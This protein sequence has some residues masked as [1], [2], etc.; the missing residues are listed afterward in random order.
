MKTPLWGACSVTELRQLASFCRLPHPCR[1]CLRGVLTSQHGQKANGHSRTRFDAAR[2]WP[3]SWVYGHAEKLCS[4]VSAALACSLPRTR[5]TRGRQFLV[6]LGC[7]RVAPTTRRSIRLTPWRF[8]LAILTA[9]SILA[10][11]LRI[12]RRQRPRRSPAL[13]RL[14]QLR[15][16]Q[17]ATPKTTRTNA[18]SLSFAAVPPACSATRCMR[19]RA[20]VWPG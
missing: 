11:P 14:T 12:C 8:S 15:Q 16:S 17:R 9:T 6:M 19:A 18:R 2:S 1:A 10:R 7:A 5:P 13:G 20:L 4:G 3:G